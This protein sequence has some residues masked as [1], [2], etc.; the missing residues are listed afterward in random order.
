MEKT[1]SLTFAVPDEATAQIGEMF[2]YI[3]E[4]ADL[5]RIIELDVNVTKK[6]SGIEAINADSLINQDVYNLQGILVKAAAT[7]EDLKALPAGLYIVGGKKVV[8]R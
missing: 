3:G 5:G 2:L 4:R 1:N 7:A 8:I 6:G